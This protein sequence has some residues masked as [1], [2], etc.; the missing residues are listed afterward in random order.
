MPSTRSADPQVIWRRLASF[1]VLDSV[2]FA[3]QRDLCAWFDSRQLH[4]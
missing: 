4:Q 1:R 2:V 3:G